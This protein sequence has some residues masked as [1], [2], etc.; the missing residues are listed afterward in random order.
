MRRLEDEAVYIKFPERGQEEFYSVHFRRLE[1]NS[2]FLAEL[3]RH[4]LVNDSQTAQAEEP[5]RAIA[6][7]YP[8]IRGILQD[9]IRFVFD[10]DIVGLDM[11]EELE[12]RLDLKTSASALGLTMDPNIPRKYLSP[13]D[14]DIFHWRALSQTEIDQV[15]LIIE[16]LRAATTKR[17]GT[18]IDKY[19]LGVNGVMNMQELYSRLAS[20]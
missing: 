9:R 13:K 3:H 5:R 8:R 14:E 4:Y 6:S 10:T 18:K 1:G 19:E 11:Y 7:I 12:Q 15:R 16:V 20:S 17:K 2:E